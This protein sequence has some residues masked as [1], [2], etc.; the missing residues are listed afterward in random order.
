MGDPQDSASGF[1][2]KKKVDESWK[3]NVEKEKESVESNSPK[4]SVEEI[5]FS[6]FLSSLG[7]QAFFA[8]GEFQ[9]PAKKEIK[10][11]LTQAKYL[12]DII[13]ILSEKTKGNLSVEESAMMEE[14]LYGLKMKFVEK[15]PKP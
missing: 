8:L 2:A 10:T 15:S 7:M 1:T 13:Q 5:S 11:D 14:L 9:D 4:E 12:I 6:S 3:D